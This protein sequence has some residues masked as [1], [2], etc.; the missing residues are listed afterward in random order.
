MSA[1]RPLIVKHPASVV[2]TADQLGIKD[3]DTEA[4]DVQLTLSSDAIKGRLQLYDQLTGMDRTLQNGDT[5]SLQDVMEGD[6]TYLSS[7]AERD[8]IVFQLSDGDFQSE[9]QLKV[10]QQSKDEKSEQFADSGVSDAD[11]PPPSCLVEFNSTEWNAVEEGGIVQ[12]IPVTRSGD[13]S[14]TCSVLCST[15]S[16][17]QQ[18]ATPS[19]D[20]ESRPVAES[21]RIFFLRGV[22]TVPCPVRI[23]DDVV[24]EGEEQFTVRLSQPQVELTVGD[25]IQSAVTGSRDQLT[26]RIRDDEDVT[27]VQFNQSTFRLSAPNVNDDFLDVQVDRKGDL[28]FASRIYINGNDG[29][30]KEGRDYALKTRR[31]DF[32]PGESSSSIRI[33]FLSKG[34]WSKNFRL[35]LSSLEAV[36]AQLG[37]LSTATVFIPPSALTPGPALLPAEPIVVSLIDY[38]TPNSISNKF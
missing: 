5:F 36:N 7:P 35:Q 9:F 30:A 25:A 16:S 34:T 3:P 22:T 28:R 37:Q 23:R 1:T 27:R 10:Q 17:R 15:E 20:Y 13:L 12:Q 32:A 11:A 18:P 14:V 33:T 38:G 24:F 2:L 21:A 8:T 31:L 6:V 19:D 26:V 4:I 29:S